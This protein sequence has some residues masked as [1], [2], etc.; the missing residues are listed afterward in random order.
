MVFG[1]ALI[2]A[3]LF[4]AASVGLAANGQPFLLGRAKNAATRVTGLVGNVAGGPALKVT[5]PSGGSALGLHVNE[6]QAPMT[7]NAEAGTATGLSADELDGNDSSAF[8][9]QA[10]LDSEAAARRGADGGLDARASALETDMGVFD[11]KEVIDQAG[12]LPLEGTYTSKG[13]T[14]VIS[15]SGSGYT[16]SDYGGYVGNMGMDI[17]VDGVH[18]GWAGK[19]QNETGQ[20]Q[21]FVS[22]YVVVDQLPAGQHTIKLSPWYV[23]QTNSGDP[24][25]VTVVEIPD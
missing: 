6:G 24:F 8:A 25:N 5:N 12:P 15:A 13:G 18:V 19:Y 11:A 10:G 20:H 4:G 7:V 16:S 3:L 9:T 14:L 17:Y 1:L 21:P 23:T 22:D 2:M